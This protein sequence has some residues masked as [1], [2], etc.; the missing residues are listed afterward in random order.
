MVQNVEDL[1]V[2]LR[3]NPN[4]RD[5][6]LSLRALYRNSQ[7]YVSLVNLIECWA[8]HHSN[9]F[10]SAE[11]FFEASDW[12]QHHLHDTARMTELLEKALEQNI[13]HD[14]AYHR[15]ETELERTHNIHK[16][17]ELYR[18]RAIALAQGDDKDAYV[19]LECKRGELY[20]ECGQLKQALEHYQKA[21]QSDPTKETAL[22][23]AQAILQLHNDFEACAS[24]LDAAIQSEANRKKKTEWLFELAQLHLN[25]LGNL[26]KALTALC[27]AHS[28]TPD[29]LDIKSELLRTLQFLEAE[30]DRNKDYRALHDLWLECVSSFEE[31]SGQR[32]TLLPKIAVLKE[33]YLGDLDGAIQ[34]WNEIL[35]FDPIHSLALS[36]LA[37]LLE[38]TSR[39]D[40]I[41]PVI[42]KQAVLAT[43]ARTKLAAYRK[44]TEIHLIHRN[45]EKEAI[46]TLRCILELDPTDVDAQKTLAHLLVAEHRYHEAAPLL[47]AQLDGTKGEERIV[48]LERLVLMCEERLSAPQKA[49]EFATTILADDPNNRCALECMARIDSRDQNYSRLRETLSYLYDVVDEDEKRFELLV[50]LGNLSETQLE[51]F[52]RAIEYYRQ[53]LEINPTSNELLNTLCKVY[54]RTGQYRELVIL[55]RKRVER[56]S[57]TPTKV[58][59]YRRIAHILT[60]RVNNHSAANEVWERIVEL[61]EDEE[62]L[63][64]LLAKST[65]AL[66][67]DELLGRI[68]KVLVDDEEQMQTFLRLA[69]LR[70]ETN[71]F[72]DA[73][74]LIETKVLTLKPD[75]VPGI[76][77]LIRCY[78]ETGDSHK[79]AT[80]LERYIANCDRNEHPQQIFAP[81]A[82]LYECQLEEH[83]KAIDV[84]LRWMELEPS[85]QYPKKRLVNLLEREGRFAELVKVL[86]T[87]AKNTNGETADSYRCQAAEI[88]AY[89]LGD[90]NLA[91]EKLA[92]WVSSSKGAQKLLEKI[93]NDFEQQQRL[94]YLW[95]ESAKRIDQRSKRRE[96]WIEA[97]HLFDQAL[98]DPEKAL[99]ATIRAFA[100]DL[101][102]SRLLDSIDE[103]AIRAS[104]W[105]RL[106][107][108]Y[109]KLV[110]RISKKEEKKRLLLRLA[111]LLEKEAGQ[112][113]DALDRVFRALGLFPNDNEALAYA[114]RLAKK[115]GRMEELLVVYEQRK[116]SA[117]QEE[118]RIRAL[119]RAAQ[120]SS[121][122]LSDIDRAF[123]YIA[124]AV[125][126]AHRAPDLL[127]LL[128]KCT[129]GLK[130][131]EAPEDSVFEETANRL[132]TLYEQ[133]ADR[134]TS[135]PQWAAELFFRAAHLAQE[136]YR[137]FRLLKKASRC[138]CA[139]Q[140]LDDLESY[141]EQLG[142]FEELDQHLSELVDQCLEQKHAIDLL[143][144]RGR[145]LEKALERHSAAADV[146]N[147]LLRLRKDDRHA[148]QCLLRCLRQS[149]RYHDLLSALE[150][151]AKESRNTHDK[152]RFLREAAMIWE[153][154]MDNRWEALDVWQQIVELCPDDPEA[155]IKVQH[156]EPSTQTTIIPEAL[157]RAAQKA[158]KDSIAK[159]LS[160]FPLG[161]EDETDT[162][163]LVSL[164]EVDEVSLSPQ[165]TTAIEFL[166]DDEVDEILISDE[167]SIEFALLGETKAPKPWFD[168][169]ELSPE[170]GTIKDTENR[171]ALGLTSRPSSKKANA[172]SPSLRRSSSSKRHSKQRSV[173]PPVPR[174]SFP[175]K[176]NPNVRSL[177]TK[178]GG[179]SPSFPN[180]FILS[181]PSPHLKT[182]KK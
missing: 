70:M 99:E 45:D 74:E 170:P 13:Q 18:R 116:S 118:T 57:D 135:G 56:E 30:L 52:E 17:L 43:E 138:L 29:N 82:N 12:V 165:E 86:D 50:R 27:N 130:N 114:E 176:R 159:N 98:D 120:I 25:Q 5:A 88:I 10:E 66:K 91:W 46:V 108:I 107:R 117:R 155:L 171:F 6:F 140:I 7:D 94:A 100:L 162:E 80:A 172:F 106:T 153:E 39:W 110:R 14:E 60:H 32:K 73:A 115:V 97:S 67:R 161:V 37:E 178:P 76:K 93:A 136:P 58:E 36:S 62:A 132:A 139:P 121:N 63:R 42:T 19:E 182:P 64:I 69:K 81:L 72:A 145:L 134:T 147:H 1:I 144:R 16:L 156:L 181:P 48:L 90:W 53:A 164:K 175:S 129:L 89:E 28:L 54:D 71:R 131:A 124:E 167:S 2:Q 79:L 173:P 177:R 123:Q 149:E 163:I 78:E 75:Y 111:T 77:A 22:Y 3:R 148:K 9:R 150:R 179:D 31:T 33:K 84:L 166:N 141:A 85:D 96:K 15:L 160:H 40:E 119:L 122:S 11:A 8:T 127:E 55:L 44:L 146:F 109:E 95:V 126:R 68:A 112:E 143:R 103:F 133:S 154:K 125:E 65:D 151:E 87:L 174:A 180:A 21:L 34:I 4:D 102:D 105:P 49:F 51:E 23:A 61:Q 47:E 41:V 59:L 128:E 38:T 152:L 35:S 137:S 157:R 158:T 142:H 169:Q 83:T 92:P 24:L 168:A 101:D 113:S 20:E 26:R 104:A